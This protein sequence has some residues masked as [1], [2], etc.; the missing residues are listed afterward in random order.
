VAGSGSADQLDAANALDGLRGHVVVCN[1]NAKV[2]RLVED[3]HRAAAPEAL[4]VVLLAQDER[5]WKQHTGWHPQVSGPGRFLVIF[6]C[7]TEERCLQ[8]ARIAEARAAVILAD[9]AQG[10]HADARSTLV[11]MA[12]ER[13]TPQVH[14]VMELLSSVNRVHLRATDVN[15]V[16]CQGDITEKLLAQSCITPGVQ[17]VFDRLLTVGEGSSA[18]VTAPLPPALI[19]ISYAELARRAIERRAPFIVVGFAAEVAVR[20]A[21]RDAPPAQSLGGRSLVI[22]PRRD[23]EPGRETLLAK[24]DLV[25]LMAR[26]TPELER[27]CGALDADAEDAGALDG[28]AAASP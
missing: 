20:R 7:P 2:K 6:G 17:N 27:Y 21:R 12:I 10:D 8:R 13:H 28:A 22:N 3:L 11:A 1:C 19:G 14:T 18:L 5:M 16:V 25:V 23:E 9:P 26:G 24:G 4:D 15:E